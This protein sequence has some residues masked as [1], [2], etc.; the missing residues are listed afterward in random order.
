MQSFA[1]LNAEQFNVPTAARGLIPV[2]RARDGL[3]ASDRVFESVGTAIRELRLPPGLLLSESELA[4]QLHVSRT[5]LREAIVRLV[6]AGLLQ[7]LPQ[8]GT[9]VAKIRMSD[10]EEA[11]FV[12][13]TLEIGAFEL[14]CAPA[15][16]DVSVLH[17]LLDQQQRAHERGDLETFFSADEA[18]HAEIFSMAGHPGAWMAVQRMKFQLDRLRRLSLPDPA[19]VETLIH[20]HRRIV[21]AIAT[22]EL[23]QGR[24]Q[25]SVHARRVLE[26]AP[27]M[28]LKFPDYFATEPRA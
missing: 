6:D 15:H 7:V 2:V 19:T 17:D 22:A 28:Q 27:L 20:D 12:R 21:D 8:V 16:R 10:V 3:R 11:R 14:A 1:D 4:Q 24:H 9:L 25:I 18:L 5:P 23:A 13:E 26:H